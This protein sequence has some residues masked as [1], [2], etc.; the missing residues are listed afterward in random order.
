MK[1]KLIK[2]YYDLLEGSIIQDVVDIGDMYEGIFASMCGS[3]IATVPKDICVELSYV[4]CPICNSNT[5]VW[6]N[7]ITNK[8]TCHRV[9]CN[10]RILE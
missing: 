6:I 2:D 3:Y 9:G 10:N 1:I 8:V 5:Q 7:Q 4:V